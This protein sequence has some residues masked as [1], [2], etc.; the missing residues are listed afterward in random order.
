[1]NWLKILAQTHSSQLMAL[2]ADDLLNKFGPCI[3][4]IEHR[5]NCLKELSKWVT[6]YFEMAKIGLE[7][8]SVS[9]YNLKKA[10][11]TSMRETHFVS[12]SWRTDS[13]FLV[14]G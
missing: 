3:G 12:V 7:Q 6:N 14:R 5:A 11:I 8:Y 1:M 2:G 13:K 9:F 10:M 4:I